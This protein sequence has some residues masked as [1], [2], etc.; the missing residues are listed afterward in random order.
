M[1]LRLDFGSEN[2]SPVPYQAVTPSGYVA[3]G[4]AVSVKIIVAN[5]FGEKVRALAKRTRPR[6][7]YDVV[8]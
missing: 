8:N 5:H 3:C 4:G 1:K 6:D 2:T 7:L